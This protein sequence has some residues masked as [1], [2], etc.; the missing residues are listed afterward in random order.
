LFKIIAVLA[1]SIFIFVV[2]IF[3]KYEYK[4]SFNARSIESDDFSVIIDCCN[5]N[6]RK[7]FNLKINDS[8][9]NKICA[10]TIIWLKNK[11]MI[12]NELGNL[13]KT[14]QTDVGFFILLIRKKERIY[15]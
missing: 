8:M 15:V 1:T 11:T 14:K 10:D 13:S 3:N 12:L 2:I 4:K 7:I 5:Q 9:K 6:Y